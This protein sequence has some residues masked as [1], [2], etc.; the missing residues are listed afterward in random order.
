M[1]RLETELQQNRSQWS[2]DTLR[3]LRP[4]VLE[5]ALGADE[6]C[7]ARGSLVEFGGVLPAS[8]ERTSR[9][10]IRCKELW[11]ET[12]SGGVHFRR[13]VEC[14]KEWWVMWRRVAAG[15][16]PGQQSEIWGQANRLLGGKESRRPQVGARPG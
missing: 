1:R 5:V 14:W 11:R 16:K 2:V 6:K 7:S 12:L 13:S 10:W 15:L 8:R 4:F 3:G 9:G